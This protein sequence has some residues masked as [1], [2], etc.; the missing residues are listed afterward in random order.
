MFILQRRKLKLRWFPQR[1]QRNKQQKWSWEKGCVSPQSSHSWH[2]CM[3]VLPSWSPSQTYRAHRY[4]LCMPLRQQHHPQSCLSH[5]PRTTCLALFPASHSSPLW[6]LV[7][8]PQPQSQ[9]PHWISAS[10]QLRPLLHPGT[11]LLHPNWG[12]PGQSQE[13]F[14]LGSL[15]WGCLLIYEMRYDLPLRSDEII[16][17]QCPVQAWFLELPSAWDSQDHAQPRRWTHPPQ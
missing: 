4:S 12:S 11:Q 5:R 3:T 15:L 7:R 17:V 9:L 10:F 6:E 16:Y 8:W 13:C 2:P 14:R 1:P